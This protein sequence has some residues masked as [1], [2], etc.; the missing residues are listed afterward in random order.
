MQQGGESYY[1]KHIKMNVRYSKND[2]L[3]DRLNDRASSI[4]SFLQRFFD[5]DDGLQHK[6]LITNKIMLNFQ[7]YNFNMILGTVLK[8]EKNLLWEC[9]KFEGGDCIHG[10]QIEVD[11]DNLRITIS[12]YENNVLQQKNKMI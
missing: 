3:I 9:P 11:S 4:K 6:S 5:K 10:R 7:T 12:Y 2:E 1:Q 8:A